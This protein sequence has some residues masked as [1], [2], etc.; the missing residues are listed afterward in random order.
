MWMVV[1]LGFA[2]GTFFGIIVIAV[3]SASEDR[4]ED[5]L[6]YAGHMDEDTWE[7][8]THGSGEVEG[9]H[10][11]SDREQDVQRDC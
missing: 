3:L 4:W 7:E 1:L 11:D 10:S 9:Q 8:L 6:Y 5:A 2:L